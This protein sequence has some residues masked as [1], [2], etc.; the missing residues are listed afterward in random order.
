MANSAPYSFRGVLTKPYALD[1]ART[2]L[3]HPSV[4]LASCWHAPQDCENSGDLKTVLAM[5]IKALACMMPT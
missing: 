3:D 5:C 2:E 1:A 4:I